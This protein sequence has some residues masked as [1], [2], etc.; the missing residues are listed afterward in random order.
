[1]SVLFLLVGLFLQERAVVTTPHP[2][3]ATVRSYEVIGMTVQLPPT[4]YVAPTG[5]ASRATA[6]LMNL[7]TVT[8]TYIDNVGT[9]YVDV[10]NETSGAAALIQAW[11]DGTGGSLRTRLLQHLIDEKKIPPARIQKGK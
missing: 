4:I 1:M 3:D 9:Q 2:V 7:T 8:I 5:G 6:P 10:H 11:L